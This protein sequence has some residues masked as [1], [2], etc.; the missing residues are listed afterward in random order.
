MLHKFKNLKMTPKLVVAFII[1]MMISSISGVTGAVMLKKSDRQYSKALVENG[2]SQGDVGKL[3]SYLYKATAVVRDIILYDSTEDIQT[4]RNEL[5]AIQQK[6]NTAFEETRVTCNTPQEQEYIER[7]ET[8]LPLYWEQQDQVIQLAAVNKDEEAFKLFHEKARPVLNEIM[9][10]TEGLVALNSRMGDEVSVTLT[11]SSYASISMMIILIVFSVV[12]SVGFAYV[13]AKSITN[14]LKVV[15]DAADKLAKGELDIQIFNDDQDEI[16]SMLESFSD[17]VGMLNAYIKDIG[18]ALGEMANG[19]FDLVP[20][21]V[22]RGSF[23]KLEDSI[24]TILNSLTATMGGIQEA[25]AQVSAGADQVSSGAQALSQGATEQASSV[26]ELAATINEISHRIQ[27][28]ADQAKAAQE[29]NAMTHDELQ[30]CSSQ[31][32]ELVAAMDAISGK[33]GEI[34][35]I[36]KTIEDIAFQTNILALNAAVEAARA[37]SAGKGFAVVADEVRN[38]AAKSAE[39]A[40]NT[41]ALIEETVQAVKEGS[42]LSA[43]TEASLTRVVENEKES[44]DAIS[45]I[46]RVSGEQAQNVTQVSQGIDQISSVV[47]TNSATAE[48]SA[49]ASEELS[50][51]A[52]MLMDLISHFKFKDQGASVS[53]GAVHVSRRTEPDWEN[54]QSSSSDYIPAAGDKY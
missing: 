18:R 54:H 28:T 14:R 31:M 33:S 37:G 29:K 7:I 34:S 46:A 45:H 13:F 25:S 50:G 24:T 2:F 1:I 8:K 9:S 22:Y 49:A 5:A 19:N 30:N 26:E 17:A 36:I 11:K 35:K 39:A 52:N 3:S 42:Q 6:V 40:K 27:E 47:Q 21:V 16:G 48:E 4:T 23:K 51:Q 15:E 38:L 53:R 41:T 10:D 43:E 12:V 32:G 44:L 20:G